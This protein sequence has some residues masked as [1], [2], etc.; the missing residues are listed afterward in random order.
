MN[1]P[2]LPKQKQ[3]SLFIEFDILGLL[4]KSLSNEFPE[5]VHL[6]AK[7]TNYWPYAKEMGFSQVRYEQL[8]EMGQGI[9][10]TGIKDPKEREHTQ[11]SLWQALQEEL[12]EDR[13]RI[14]IEVQKEI[15]HLQDRIR[16]K[17]DSVLA[18]ERLDYIRILEWHLVKNIRLYWGG[19]RLADDQAEQEEPTLT[20]AQIFGHEKEA[21]QKKII[22]QRAIIKAL[23]RKGRKPDKDELR[24]MMDENRL[25]S[26][27]VN[28]SAVGREYGRTGDTIKRWIG[29]YHLKDYAERGPA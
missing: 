9:Y 21:L 2:E 14:R 1:I 6:L 18:K 13:E 7:A 23:L 27:R 12:I 10:K 5:E 20:E 11:Y 4:D 25:K 22:H 17:G 29:E 26:G 24:K 19:E 3:L 8:R 15:R 28:M 16:E